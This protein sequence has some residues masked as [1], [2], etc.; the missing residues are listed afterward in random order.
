MNLVEIIK[1]SFS[2]K[3]VLEQA[4]SLVLKLNKTPVLAKSSPGFIVNRILGPYM[5]EA[6]KLAVDK[7]SIE[8]TDKAVKKFGLPMG[9]FELL[10]EVGLDIAYKVSQ[11]LH[12]E[13]GD[14]MQPVTLLNS[15]IENKALGKKTKIGIYEY[16]ENL[17]RVKINPNVYKLIFNA[18]EK[19]IIDEKLE[20]PKSDEEITDRLIMV[21]LNEA[22]RLLASGIVEDAA[23]LDLAMVFG[24]GFAPHH[25][26]LIKYADYIGLETIYQKLSTLCQIY[27]ENY[28]P[29][30]ILLELIAKKQSFY[31]VFKAN[32]EN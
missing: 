17:R 10:D 1:T 18:D 16:D 15:L 22:I 31:D 5:L 25:G 30:P 8:K 23:S 2:D 24:T 21:M 29:Q 7:V 19:T 12:T 4:K 3:T 32:Y 13:L 20:N 11:I 9:P 6:V 26:G 28:A 14:R 27:G